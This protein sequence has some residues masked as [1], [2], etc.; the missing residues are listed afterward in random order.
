MLTTKVK[1]GSITNLTDA[2]YF[3]A[4]EVEWLGFNFDTGA[5]QSIS[6]AEMLA[7]REWVDGPKMVGE[8]NLPDAQMLKDHIET[9]KLDAI[10]VGMFTTLETLLELNASI[11]VLKEI[12]IDTDTTVE[13]LQE[14]V[15]SFQAQVAHF[16][17][18]FQKNQLSWNQIEAGM[19][20]SMDVLQ[21]LCQENS[22][23]LNFD[24]QPNALNTI[25]E[26]IQPTGICVQ[27]GEEEKVGF[28][29]FDELD[30][31]FEAIEL[32]V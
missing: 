16:I 7:I 30:E 1:A 28:K 10:Q 17:L 25:L 21:Q 14:Q 23:L 12:V 9:L 2:R 18:D 20:F 5:D 4:W 6:P 31:I 22:I 27:G 24:F 15:E 11:P 26:T 19:P 29:S 8:F 32:Q 3:S 13:A